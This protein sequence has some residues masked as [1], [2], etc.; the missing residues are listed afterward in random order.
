MLPDDAARR[1]WPDQ[2]SANVP[3]PRPPTIV[4][5]S[6]ENTEAIT[7]EIKRYLKERELQVSV[8]NGMSG[9]APPPKRFI[10]GS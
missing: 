8:S 3:A 4:N 6:D 2:R 10:P 7:R 5:W 1:I 9:S